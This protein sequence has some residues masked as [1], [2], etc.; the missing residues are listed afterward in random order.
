MTGSPQVGKQDTDLL[1]GD[2]WLSQ[3]T[4]HPQSLVGRQI[5]R[6]AAECPVYC[7]TVFMPESSV[8]T[9][10]EKQH[11]V[12]EVGYQTGVVGRDREGRG[13]R[14]EFFLSSRVL[15]WLEALSHMTVGIRPCLHAAA[16]IIKSNL[17]S[18]CSTPVVPAC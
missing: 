6:E 15:E 9:A 16:W 4:V 18:S 14:D 2:Y 3:G 11:A 10:C 13:V 5:H 1:S 17:V 8:V 7:S 12:L